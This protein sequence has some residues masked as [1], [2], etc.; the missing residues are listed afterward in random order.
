MIIFPAID[1]RGGKVVRLTEGDYDRMQTYSREPDFVAESFQGQGATHLH[2]VD[3]DAAKDGTQV[4]LK[5]IEKAIARS[6]LITQVGGGARDE[7]SVKRYLDAGVARVILGTLLVEQPALAERLAAKH[8]G[9]IAASVDAKDGKVAIHGWREVTD[10][11]ALDFMARLPDMGI[12]TAVYTD[13]GKDGMMQG[14]NIGAYRELAK[15][16][17]LN[18]IASGGISGK[19]DIKALRKLNVYGAVI[20][21]AL[22]EGLLD[23]GVAI[24]L[25]EVK[26]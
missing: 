15:I 20:G 23:L 12:G 5:A 6:G 1:L 9:Q 26:K 25:A 8:P 3:L 18:V 7:D 4:N 2:M 22:Y 14:T 11:D 13:I 16:G 19:A 10:R 21:K 17:G 24:K